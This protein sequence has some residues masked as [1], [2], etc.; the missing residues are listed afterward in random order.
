MVRKSWVV[1]GSEKSPCALGCLDVF[2]WDIDWASVGKKRKTM[3]KSGQHEYRL[4]S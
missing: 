2:G 4:E 1:I 3:G